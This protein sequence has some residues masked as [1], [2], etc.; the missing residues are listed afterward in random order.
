MCGHENVISAWQ[1]PVPQVEAITIMNEGRRLIKDSFLPRL[2]DRLVEG[3]GTC[4]TADRRRG[5]G[6]G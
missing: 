4:A 3:R 5:L 6:E 1:P 2:P